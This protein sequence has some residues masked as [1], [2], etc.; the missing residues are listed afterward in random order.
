M[1][2]AEGG[3][4]KH[5]SSRASQELA[6]AFQYALSP[7]EPFYRHGECTEKRRV[8]HFRQVR[9]VTS[10]AIRSAGMPASRL[11]NS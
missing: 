1:I 6:E 4:V 7:H 11:E 8:G 2:T 9:S 3:C 5:F 10:L